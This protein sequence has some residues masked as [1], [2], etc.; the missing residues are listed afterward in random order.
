MGLI[1]LISDFIKRQRGGQS[2][3]EVAAKT[4]G[5]TTQSAQHF[6]SPGEDASPLPGD[7]VIMVEG[8]T[9][10]SRAA[11]GYVAPGDELKTQPGERRTYARNADGATVSQ[12][13]Q[14]ADGRVVIQNQ[15]GG[16]ISMAA[17]GEVQINGVK[18]TTAGDVISATGISLNRHRHA[19]VQAGQSTTLPPTPG[20]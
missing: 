17:S 10:A 12:V 4:V 11:V 1:G 7:R 8:P 13:W 20:A 2:F 3:G 19:G 16:V 15:G 9:S 6:G 5:G 14:Y 18:I